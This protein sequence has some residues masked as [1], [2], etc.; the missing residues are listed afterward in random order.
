M[1]ASPALPTGSKSLD[2]HLGGLRMGDNVIWY[3]DAGSL[4]WSFSRKFI[5]KSLESNI[6][7]VYVTCDRSPKNLLGKLGDLGRSPGLVVL[8]CFSHGKGEG[9]EI[10][11]RF[12]AARSENDLP[13][14]EVMPDPSDPSLMGQC[15][16]D[17]YRR[18]GDGC[19]FVVESLTGLRDLW[20]GEEAVTAFYRAACPRLFELGTLVYWVCEKK[21]HSARFRAEIN[22]IGQVAMELCL[23]RGTTSLTILKGEGRQV[24][25]LGKSINYWVDGEDIAFAG[26]GR[27]VGPLAMGGRLKHA[28]KARGFS[29]N[30]L[31]RLVGVTAS[32]ISQV[33]GNQIL[34]SLPA[35][36][37][38]AEVL[39]V[40]PGSLLQQS[41][42]TRAAVFSQSLATKARLSYNCAGAVQ[43]T[44]LMPPGTSDRVTVY[45]IEI[46][47]RGLLEGHFLSTK[48]HEM[49]YV[50]SGRTMLELKERRLDLNPG[51][52]VYLSDDIPESWE[53]P[54]MEPARLLW[55]KLTA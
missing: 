35:L 19:R 22:Q 55:L 4:A 14:V 42:P 10:F 33:E 54:A 6:P 9:A 26:Q 46:N 45:L 51:D 12:H 34:P 36:I 8:D 39:E 3:D 47:P 27:A 38:M 11:T 52:F 23:K 5:S 28:R 18:L 32:N 7:V 2:R 24:E 48:A 30:Q 25:D 21:A 17:L 41:S 53:N 37:R 40:E 15:F 1:N 20:G 31:A 43:G 13:K 50:L 49:G 29:Q 16:Y 44:M